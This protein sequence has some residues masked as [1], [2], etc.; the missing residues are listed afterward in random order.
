MPRTFLLAAACAAFA[1]MPAGASQQCEGPL[2]RDA[3][4]FSAVG[5]GS[6]I[7]DKRS[8]LIWMRCVED[9]T[10]NG[11][12]CVA[13]D[14]EAVN[15]GPRL[16]F[17]QAKALAVSKSTSEEHWRVPSRKEL[18]T[19]RE[20]N[21]YNPSLN[22]TLFPTKPA[23]SSDGAFWTSTPEG[24]GVS[25]VSA[26]GSSDAWATTDEGSTNHVRLVRTP[27]SSSKK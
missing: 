25:L 15:P 4:D 27:S 10:W 11:S 19:L 9:Q 13:N 20:P 23:W 1:C 16:T 24:K 3:R 2:K 26:I 22:L 21:C 14:P 7:Y 6:Q 8:H 5:D 12:M 18:L 17:Q